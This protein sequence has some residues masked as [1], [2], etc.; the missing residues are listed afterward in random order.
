MET[1]QAEQNDPWGGEEEG[2]NGGDEFGGDL[3]LRAEGV[4]DFGTGVEEDLVGV[5]RWGLRWGNDEVEEFV[6]RRVVL[7][8]ADVE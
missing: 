5:L 6:L 7:E 3:L 2:E 4:E 8:R 1:Y